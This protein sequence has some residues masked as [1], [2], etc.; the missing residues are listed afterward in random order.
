[1]TPHPDPADPLDAVPDPDTVRR[2]LA[3]AVRRRDLLRSL[4]RVAVRRANYPPAAGSRPTPPADRQAV[5]RG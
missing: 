5:G 1:M 4:L 2:M 3:D